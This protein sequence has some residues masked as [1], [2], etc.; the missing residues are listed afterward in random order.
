MAANFG[1]GDLRGKPS[2]RK[3]KQN[4][5]GL[6]HTDTRGGTY[7]VDP[8]LAK[9][10]GQGEYGG[11]PPEGQTRERKGPLNRSTGRR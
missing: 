2:G 11:Q 8:A 5:S 10:V 9:D 3:E 1:N 6:E 4:A 7:D